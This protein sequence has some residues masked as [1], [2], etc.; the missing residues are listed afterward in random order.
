MKKFFILSLFFILSDFLAAQ[1]TNPALIGYW[2]NWNDTKAPYIPLDQVDSAYTIINIA[3][4]EPKAGTSYSM[5]FNPDMVSTSTLKGQIKTLQNKG[6]KVLISIGGANATIA[7]NTIA[8]RDSFITT[9]NSIIATFGFDGI[10]IDLEGSS[11]TVSGGTIASPVDAKIN[12]LIAAIKQIMADFYGQNNTKMML[13]M[14]PET[15]FVQGGM[16]AYSGIWGAYL[17]IIEA[18]RDSIDVLHVQLYNSGSMYGIDKNIYNQ[19]SA[20]F[21]IAMTEAVIK[22]FN[23]AGGTYSGLPAHKVAVGLPACPSAAGG[24]YTDTATVKKALDYLRG[25]GTQP[26]SYAL[27]QNGGYP[28]LRGMMTWSIN[29]DA[30]SDCAT[31]YEYATN[32][33]K[34]FA[35]P[36]AGINAIRLNTLSIK[37]NPA[38]DAI[39]IDPVYSYAKSSNISIYNSLG[40]VVLEC[41]AENKSMHLDISNLPNGIYLLKYQDNYYK[42]IKN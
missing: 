11:I 35:K 33:N 17:P 15:A 32:F 1:N 13:T 23:T 40:T 24:G 10:D 4:A 28:N 16:S 9:M 25:S 3:F 29:W 38:H 36:T 6:K 20:D 2:H 30:R 14:A 5:V 21:I 7:L 37:P 18:L 41:P 34:I 19:G 22:G 39:F 26:G 42:F 27:S 8:E 31:R 12:H